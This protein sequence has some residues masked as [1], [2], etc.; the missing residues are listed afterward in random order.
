MQNGFNL[1]SLLVLILAVAGF[2]IGIRLCNRLVFRKRPPPPAGERCKC[3]YPLDHLLVPRCPECGRV[4]HFDATPEQLGL[5]DEHLRQAQAARERRK[6]AD[7]QQSPI[8]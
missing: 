6:Q 7:A 4:I 8:P 2:F 3:G 1:L 5:T